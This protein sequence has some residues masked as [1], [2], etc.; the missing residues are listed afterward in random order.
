M[1]VS[2]LYAPTLRETPAEAEVVSHKLL[3]RA[4]FIRKLS[5]G[6]YTY[7]PLAQRV[8]QKISAI[9]REEMNKAGG[10]EVIMP[11]IQ[12]AELWLE[13]GRWHVYGKELFRLKDRHER[14]FCLG[15][16]HE[17][18]ITDLVRMDI[19]SYRQL[20]LMLYQIQNK[21]RDERRPRFGL[22]R[23]RE[24]IMKDLYSFDRDEEGLE[25]SY[26]KMFD[27]YNAVFNRCGLEFRPVEADSGAIGG[28]VSH[29]FMVIADSGEAAIVYC[30]SC[31][32]AA[33][34]EIAPCFPSENDQEEQLPVKKVETPGKSNIDEVAAFLKVPARKLIKT[35]LFLVDGELIA[36]LAR[37]DRT[38]N[39]IKVQRLH[40]SLTF[41]MAPAERI[42]EAAGCEPGYVGPVGLKERGVKVYADEEVRTMNNAVCGANEENYHLLN[43]VP[44][45][46]FKVTAYADLRQIEEGECCP[47]CGAV[48]S[49][50][51]GIEVGQIFKLGTKYSSALKANYVDENGKENLIVMGCYGIGISR[52]MAAAVEQN[53]DED[54]II[55]PVA[56]APYHAVVIPVS[57]SDD[58]MWQAAVEIYDSLA[59]SG[60]EVV[61]DDRDERAGV[62][63]KDAD[64]IG[65]PLRITVGKKLLEE[66]VLEVK[67][68]Q[69]KNV[70]FVQRNDIIDY[71]KDILK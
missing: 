5:S 26:R 37:G 27:A 22:M 16:T 39:E 42:R 51:R 31:S 71:V 2:K 24:F 68:R 25:E 33:N 60:V 1:H 20:P 10:Q 12:P 6:V 35:L 23:G 14:E 61:L 44:G 41:E 9:V 34:A 36:V 58:R 40:P 15:P 17:E 11:V 30:P 54:G 62:K 7:L 59:K 18:V 63:F 52:T 19:S 13:S 43:V 56:I 50:A 8:L 47:A 29:E 28:S 4:G 66:N 49:S 65:Y 70:S 67:K 48:L 32:Y 69:E 3:V 53:H 57:I 64:L 46:D 21:Y 55:W 45:R 38:V